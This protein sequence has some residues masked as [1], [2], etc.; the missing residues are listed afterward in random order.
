M[1]EQKLNTELCGVVVVD[2]GTGLTSFDVVAKMRKIYGTRRIGHTG[3]LD[4]DA[5]GVLVI[6]V[7][8]AAKAAEYITAGEKQYF[9][10]LK[11]GVTTDTEDTTGEVLTRS[12]NI[13]D[14][15]DVVKA[16]G[17]F[18]GD[19]MQIPP[20][21]SALK[22]GGEKLVDLARRGITV[23]REAR[24]VKIYA[25]SC[26]PTEKNDEFYLDVTCSHGT[27]I[28][29]LCADIGAKLGCGGCMAALRRKKTGGFTLCDAHTLEEIA[30]A[31]EKYLMPTDSLFAECERMEFSGK[32][33]K[34]IK[35][36]VSLPV[37]D[38]TDGEKVRLYDGDGFFGLGEVKD[39]RVKC[40]KFFS[41]DQ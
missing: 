8:R 30:E 26:V 20:M 5:T 18:L 25:I 4:P 6:L 21:Y 24:P 32:D 29:T 3:T 17:S 36:G 23:E 33:L 10:T 11:L 39:G 1:K 27:Y 37:K 34:K 19:Y 28:R 16:A 2:K 13:P 31:P 38:L 40:V 35:N 14:E 41:L 15:E 12:D 22:R 7:G 9:A